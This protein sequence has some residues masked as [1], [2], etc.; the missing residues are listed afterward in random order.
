M[1]TFDELGKD[2]LEPIAA[3]CRRS[4]ADPPT[5]DEIAGCLFAPDQPSVVR[6]DPEVGVVATAQ[7]DGQG[8]VRLLVVDPAH[9]GT[10][11]GHAL[12]ET[13]E[14]DLAGVPSVTVGS[15]A[16]Y[17]LFP[18]V[19]TTETGMLVLLERHHYDRVEANYNMSVDLTALPPD[20]G[21]YVIPNA[22]ERVEVDD[23]MATH[24]AGWRLEVMRAFDKGTLLLGR[25]ENG[26][27]GFCAY[28]VNRG[29]LIGPVAARFDLIGKGV[30]AP[31]IAGTLHR[32]R[33][34]GR[35]AAE[36]V[37]VGPIVPYARVGGRVSRVFFVYRRLLPT[38]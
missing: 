4:L 38:A 16:P 11:H 20:Q 27:T 13:A 9:R 3:L 32:L 1:T 15:D 17:F 23:W 24:W 21:G 2:A 18:G 26:I 36:V 29:G 28:N 37:W 7:I 14:A 25:D 10:G 35:D 6:G 5:A 31:L 34:E 12:L 19:E 33:A 8:F 22:D 30:A